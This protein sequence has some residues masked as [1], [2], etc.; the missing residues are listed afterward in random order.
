MIHYYLVS[1]ASKKRQI[2]YVHCFTGD[3]FGIIS[4]FNIHSSFIIPTTERSLNMLFVS[5][6]SVFWAAQSYAVK[7]TISTGI[8]RRDFFFYSC[9]CL[10]P[11]AA[12]MALVTPVYF[13]PTLWLIP[14]FAVS[15]FLRYGKQIAE[16]STMEKLVPYESEAYMCL[17]VILAYII[18][19]AAAIKSFTLWGCLSIVLAVAGV[20]LISDV[21]LQ[22]RKLRISLIIRI[23]CDVGLGFVTRYALLFCSNSLYILLLNAV[24]VL[25]WAHKYKLHSYKD[26]FPVIKLVI[27]Q[28]ALGFICLFLGNM[29]AQQSVTAY[30]FIRPLALAF[31]ILAAFVTKKEARVPKVKD[32]AAGALII[33]GICLQA[34]PNL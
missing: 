23:V 33:G 7:K 34:V 29:A 3:S 19:C 14:I 24:I 12:V 18:D 25:L 32:F 11:F 20:F 17:G 1:L 21:K 15:V 27:I 22:I 16:A 26:N 10:L 2:C 31:C 4:R 13:T 5:F 30:A 9:L 6:T 8:A 28:Q